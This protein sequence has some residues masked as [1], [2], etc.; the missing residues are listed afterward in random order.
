M[1]VRLSLALLVAIPAAMAYPWDSTAD[2]W[3]LGVA[4]GWVVV[5]FAWWRGLFVTTM[6]ARRI[7]MWRR[8]GRAHGSHHSSEFA[9]VALRVT[10][11]TDEELPLDLLVGYLDRYGIDFDKVRVSSRDVAGVRTTWIGLTLGAVDNIAALSARS[12]S[13]PL[14]DTA[15]LCARR[16]ADRL[17]ELGWEVSDADLAAGARPLAATGAKETW[18]AVSDEQGH[19]AAYRITVDE[20]LADTLAAVWAAGAAET[21]TA[22][23]LTGSRAHPELVAVCALRSD[24]RPAAKAP[25][26]GL[27]P[28]HGLHGVV[29]AAL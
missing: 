6:I 11:R 15:E 27:S 2:R 25:L 23:E 29:L 3:L 5:L 18:R 22:L 8:R 1:M 28:Y 16:L 24:D 26:S 7:A 4:I 17:R 12:A 21:W 10:P 20:E 19:L 13:I 14:R 9:T